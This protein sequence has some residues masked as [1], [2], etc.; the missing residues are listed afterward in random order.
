MVFSWISDYSM[1]YSLTCESGA[2]LVAQAALLHWFKPDCIY[3][4][5]NEELE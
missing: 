5:F 3:L 2:W 1:G 4:Q